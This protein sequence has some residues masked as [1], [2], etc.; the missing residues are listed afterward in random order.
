[1]TANQV[2]GPAIHVQGLEKSYKKLT[3]QGAMSGRRTPYGCRGSHHQQEEA[4]H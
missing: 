4:R 1:M 2:Q 3:R